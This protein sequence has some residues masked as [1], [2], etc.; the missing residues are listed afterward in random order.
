M[1]RVVTGLPKI[2]ID[3]E[4]VCKGCAHEN[5]TKNPYPNSDNKEK[6][7]LDIIHSDICRP[8]Q[9]TSLSRYVYYDSF[10][11][12]YSR[13]TWIYLLKKKDEVFERFKYFKALVKNLSKKKI[14]I[15]RLDNGGE[16]TS[17]EFNEY[18]KE[19]GIKREITIPYNPQQNGVAERKNISIMEVVKAMIH[20]QYLPIYIWEE[21]ARIVVY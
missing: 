7:I 12:D 10:I 11:D 2:Q 5:N 13:K 8:M 14:K 20:D 15:L 16:F 9:T 6:G 17:S 1:T 4:G 21:E 18:C 19:A 3:H